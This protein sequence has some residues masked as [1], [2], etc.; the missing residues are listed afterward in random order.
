VNQVADNAELIARAAADGGDKVRQVN[1]TCPHDCPDACSIVVSVDRESQRA[2]RV[3]GNPA[4]PVTRGFL[5]NKVNHYLEYVDSP[6]R[7]LYPHRR[8]GPRGPGAKFERI[9]WDT[10]LTEI[11]Q[12]LGGIV[13]EYGP[14]AVQPFSYSGTLGALGFS[15]MAD[16]FFNRMGAARLARTICTAAG[17][18]AKYATF[19]PV[20]D[21]DIERIPEM[22]VVILWATN[23]A[24][25]GVHLVPFINQA[26]ARG[27]TII[28]ID[29]RV[30]RTTQLA[31]W[32]I[33][34][35]PGTDAALALGMMREI[36][37]HGLHD[38][39]FL[40]EHT[41][42][43]D[44]FAGERLPEYTLDKVEAV[45]GVP[46]ADVAKLALLYGRTRKSF[47]R[48]NWG[49]QRHDNG[50]MTTRAILVLGVITGAQR[51]GGGI[52]LSTGPEMRGFDLNYLQGLH[53][54]EGRTPRTVNMIQLGDALHNTLPE[55]RLTP[56]I[57]ALFC[58]NSDPANCVPDSNATRHGLKREDLYTVVH[59]TFFTDTC[60]YADL[61]L[62]ADTQL[63]HMDLFGAY[64]NYYFSVSQVA[65][66]RRGESLDNQELFRRLARA[67]GYRD[68]CF[69]ET[70]EEMIR[71]L[72]DPKVNPLFEGISY[73]DLERDGYARGAVESP[74]R[75]GFN[76]KR[77]PTPSGKIEI[78]SETL[79]RQG[80]DAMPA[81]V[82]EREGWYSSKRCEYPLQVISAATHYAIGASF[83]GVERLN[84]MQARPTF[85]LNTADAAARGI[86]DGDFC[87]LYNDRGETFGY[88]RIV[89]G[90]LAGVLGAPKQ[91]YGSL[92]PGGVNLNALTGQQTAD[93]GGSPVYYSTLAEIEKHAA[94][95][96]EAS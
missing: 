3:E 5:C 78:Y 83:Q 10:A 1:V 61:I 96:K 25:T 88:A 75:P 76:S 65:I 93:M 29:P 22:E 56:P 84:A 82:P 46:A 33:Q 58:W 20:S 12:R 36:V 68:A 32:H 34:P 23:V 13:A 9:S 51:E 41:V 21:A 53:L 73:E 66:P 39:E 54:L 72:I 7:M 94:L 8:I 11:A 60:D 89:D 14:E 15:G 43:W 27:A 44:R 64:G 26:K 86:A 74:R 35:R 17:A 37:E 71:R 47:I 57:K 19:G 62:P 42:G 24:S 59:D 85:E 6:R 79:A 30:T 69:D 4:H 91:L 52:C 70:D 80:H 90:T 28:A 95:G 67:M 63:E 77:W 16:R 45:T 92:T 81:Y 40:A 49:I 2:I 38:A 50:G 55:G 31:D 18:A 48:L 87:R